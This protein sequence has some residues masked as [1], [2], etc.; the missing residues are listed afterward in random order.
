MFAFYNHSQQLIRNK[1]AENSAG[2]RKI[3]IF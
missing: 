3:K 2:E 1:G